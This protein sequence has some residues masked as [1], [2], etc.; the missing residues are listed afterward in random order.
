L[1]RRGFLDNTNNFG[2]NNSVN[3]WNITKTG[4]KN[5]I[6]DAY[7]GGNVWAYPNGT[8]FSQT[9]ADSNSDEIC[10]SPY[11]LD[12]NNID[13]LPLSMNFTLDTT[14]PVSIT[15]LT[16]VSNGTTWLNWSWTNPSDRDFAYV[17]IWINNA[18]HNTTS[19]T[20]HF[21][22]TSCV[23]TPGTVY[24]IAT[25]TVDSSGNI[26]QTWINQTAR[27]ALSRII[28]VDASG[29]ANYT[30]IQDAID[31]ASAGDT[32]LVYS[33]TYYENVDV[34]KQLVL[35][36][37]DNG[38]GKPVIDAQGSGS[39]ITLSAG[40]STLEGFTTMN[41]TRFA[42]IFV[43]S[44]SNIIRNNN[45]SSNVYGIHLYY[46]SNNNTLSNNNVSNN[47]NGILLYQ[48]SNNM[49]SGNNASNNSNGIYVYFS[50]NNSLNDNIA[51][52][53]TVDG[54]LIEKSNNN[55]LNNNTANLNE[56][57]IVLM[58]RSNNN[59]LNN[60]TANLNKN[61]QPGI[62][63]YN[64]SD[65]VLTN[66]TV[67][68]NGDGIYLF[69]FSNNNKII[70]NNASN[71][72]RGIYIYNSDNNILSDNTAIYDDWGVYLTSS[73][74]N[75]LNNNRASNNK[76]G[77]SLYLYSNNNIIS[78][79]IA[80]DN[81]GGISIDTG[82]NNTLKDC[83]VSNNT[84]FGVYLS[85]SNNNIYNNYFNNTNNFLFGGEN[86]NND[87]NI[88]KTSGTNIVDGSYLGG[89]V[90]TYPNG[91]GFSQTCADS[92]SDGICDSS[93][94]L[95][96]N[97]ID[98]LPLAYT[99]PTNATQTTDPLVSG[100]NLIALSIIPVPTIY[101]SNL[102]YTTT[103]GIPG[104]IKV[105]RWNPNAQQWEGY[106]YIVANGI[107]LG[108]NFALEVNNGYFI[109]GNASTAGQTYTFKGRR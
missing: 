61:Y 98:Y 45:A 34:N 103:G 90:W 13:Y 108:N 58:D 75:I 16:L 17:A 106:E 33:G 21:F 38:G 31:N 66:N 44:N 49:L 57:D 4:G 6:G 70:G 107:Y 47:S 89:N 43:N 78:G 55:L 18:W 46:F 22:N 88:T 35:R 2:I 86:N 102:L 3:L 12:A 80:S 76:Y 97:N 77:L 87:W 73:S 105:M 60:N 26:N 1:P 23:L 91:T 5:I 42:G 79:N 52:S 53:N 85:S 51:N 68:K 104:V 30:K 39:A 15:G 74:S 67:F 109:K 59:V 92:N 63:L 37:I 64:S 83:I 94:T 71:N 24:T 10:D 48:S 14:P 84:F 9:C 100:Y 96:S 40:M 81:E 95:D 69:W 41:A 82:N 20:T 19:N 28:T 93:Y 62:Y 65:N 29:G 25:H 11:V 99:Q 36:G 32:I 7:L 56:N 101:A 50:I 54:I 72:Y 27:T 8:G